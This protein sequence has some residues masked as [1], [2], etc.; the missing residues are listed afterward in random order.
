MR[1]FSIIC[2]YIISFGA[3]SP[4]DVKVSRSSSSTLS[5]GSSG[6]NKDKRISSTIVSTRH[7]SPNLGTS[8][9]RDLLLNPRG[10]Q[11]SLKVSTKIAV[12]TGSLLAFNSGYVN[13][14]CLSGILSSDNTKQASAAVTG[15]WTNSALG[16]ASGNMDQF[17]FNAKC[18]LGYILGS[19]ISG[20]LIPNPVPYEVPLG[21]GIAFL[22]GS[23]MLFSSSRIALSD[24]SKGYLYLAA[25]A[26]GIQNSITSALTSNLVRTTHFSG[27][28]SDIGTFLGQILRGNNM[29]LMK[30]KVV[31]VFALSFWTGGLCSFTAANELASSSLLVSAFLYLVI[32][33]TIVFNTR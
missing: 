15:A 3:A 25:I 2:V 23:G 20:S 10:G 14:I 11:Q 21:S 1:L 13:G 6:V 27:I 9:T 16:V 32:G 31:S 19:T 12:L 30:L 17:R 28:S 4:S 5:H 7:G 26:N 22:I 33:A 18:I 29:N 24:G 8:S